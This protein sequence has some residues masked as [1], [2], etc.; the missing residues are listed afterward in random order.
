[1]QRWLIGLLLPIFILVI[2]PGTSSALSPQQEQ[3]L[4][5]GIYYFDVGSSSE[6][7]CSDISL[8]GSDNE[9][10]IFNFY[11]AK[12]LSPPQAAG[13]T[14]NIMHESS[15]DPQNIQNPAGRTQDPTNLTSQT[16]GYG[17]I[18]WTPGNRIIGLMKDAGI[19]GPVY[20]LGSQLELIWQH[21][22]N[23]P[24]VTQTFDL[25]YYKTLTDYK[26]TTAYFEEK[27][28]GAGIVA[29]DSRLTFALRAL[30][31]YGS[32]S[33]AVATGSGSVTCA[34][35]E[36]NTEIVGD[37]SLPVN[38][39]FYLQ[40]KDW[41]TK[42]HH[43]HP[44][45]DIPVPTG[46]AV[47]SMTNGTVT[48]APVGA[49]CGLGV[50]I[51]AGDSVTFVYCHGQDGGAV[52]KKGDRVKA[53][54]LI[55]HSDNTGDSTGPHLH[56]GITINNVEHCPQNLFVGIADGN[57]PDIKSLPTDNCIGGHI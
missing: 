35:G 3:I 27:I 52:V 40:H 1:M 30:T 53:G 46:T 18:Q 48:A 50:Q 11:I 24:V 29:E 41:F 7:T 2:F 5:S 49:G 14:G 10:K 55:M 32:G 28:E 33:S 36:S 34:D 38:K 56:V 51:D 31:K 12:G 57:I 47:Y 4:Q 19:D 45:A 13:V 39:K 43:D 54:Q 16:Q 26:Q 42:P 6:S 37:Y 44:A 25:D 15:G 21:M 17:L 22:N 23:H 9:Q 8:S 20:E